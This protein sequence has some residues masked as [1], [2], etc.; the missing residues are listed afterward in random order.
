MDL[1]RQSDFWFCTFSANEIAAAAEA[2]GVLSAKSVR[3]AGGIGSARVL[4]NE[5]QQKYQMAKFIKTKAR[6]AYEI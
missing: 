5:K 4:L 3:M 1:Y 2:A 6:N